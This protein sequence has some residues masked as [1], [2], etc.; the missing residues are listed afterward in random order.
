MAHMNPHL[1]GRAL[2]SHFGTV[3]DL[4]ELAVKNDIKLGYFQV[5]KWLARDRV[6]QEGLV[7]LLQLGERLGKPI[8]LLDMINQTVDA[9]VAAEHPEW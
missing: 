7:A 9:E 3:T 8:N 4:H 6:S 5:R 2:I 1:S